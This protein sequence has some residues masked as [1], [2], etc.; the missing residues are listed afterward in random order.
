MKKKSNWKIL[1]TLSIS[2]LILSSCGG[3]HKFKS[4]YT[5]EV[6]DKKG[7]PV[8]GVTIYAISNEKAD[9]NLIHALTPEEIALF[10]GEKNLTSSFGDKTDTSGKFSLS[11][12]LKNLSSN[13]NMYLLFRK[14]GYKS[15]LLNMDTGA[16]NNT[17]V[18]L[19]SV[20]GK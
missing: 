5:G 2:I 4:T 17:E 11:L 12:E 16:H 20:G 13:P 6:L 8:K 10:K 19:D 3:G 15:V 14:S 9:S 18:K 1:S 7:S